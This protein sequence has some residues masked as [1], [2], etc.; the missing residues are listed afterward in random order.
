MKTKCCNTDHVHINEDSVICINA[1]CENYLGTAH[2]IPDQI[3]WKNYIVVSVFV[4]YMLFSFDDFSMENKE[5]E[6]GLRLQ[7]GSE[8]TPLTIENLETELKMQNIICSREVLAQ[9]KIESGN[10]KSFLLKR[11]NNMLGMRYPFNR[12]TTACGIYIPSKD[13]IIYGVRK[14]LKE[15]NK[16]NNYAVY[17]SW[18]DAVADYKLWQDACFKVSERYLAFLGNVYA[19]DSLYTKKIKEVAALSD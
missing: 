6:F 2:I 12:K 3:K 16:I 10:L 13:T 1:E 7:L 14:E 15:Y 5:I 17:N 19:E 4:F 11:T 9:I 18:K 8:E